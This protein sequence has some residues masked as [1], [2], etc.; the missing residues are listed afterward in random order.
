MSTLGDSRS[1]TDPQGIT[2]LHAAGCHPDDCEMLAGHVPV[3]EH[4]RYVHR[5]LI[6]LVLKDG[7]ERLSYRVVVTALRAGWTSAIDSVT[8][9]LGEDVVS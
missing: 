1:G 8:W 3:N 5:E 7:L 4:G 2:K 9:W 6:D